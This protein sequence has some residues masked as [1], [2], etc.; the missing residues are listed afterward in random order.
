MCKSFGE[1]LGEFMALTAS[2]TTT[3]IVGNK[4]TLY[5]YL[6][7]FMEPFVLRAVF[8]Y[9]KKWVH[10][11][12]MHQH[13][14]A[15]RPVYRGCVNIVLGL[16]SSI[17]N[18]CNLVCGAESEM[19]EPWIGVYGCNDAGALHV[20]KYHEI[21]TNPQLRTNWGELF[22]K[23][24][25]Y[26]P[27]P[28]TYA[29]D[30][31]VEDEP[32]VVDASVVTAIAT[33]YERQTPIQSNWCVPI[34]MTKWQGNYSCHVCSLPARRSQYPIEV[35]TQPSE[36][37]MLFVEYHHPELVSPILLNIPSSMMM[38]GNEILSSVFV[39]KLLGEKTVFDSRYFLRFMDDNISV[40]EIQ[41]NQFMRLHESTYTIETI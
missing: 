29:T 36:V 20:L 1:Q 13:R 9:N 35:E 37:E 39:L 6:Q 27:L 38:I 8:W 15:N 17:W 25:L 14:Y 23:A 28:E 22:F 12:H 19:S 41:S 11:Q 21:H 5:A 30:T 33:Q 24:W 16:G 10:I 7:P 26:A 2:Y 3:W 34:V 18:V 4:A 32:V 31:E 40:G